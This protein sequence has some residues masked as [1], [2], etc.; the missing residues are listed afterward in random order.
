MPGIDARES[1][2]D[3]Y[4]RLAQIHGNYWHPSQLDRR[5]RPRGV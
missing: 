5:R 1:K 2:T 3:V 4:V